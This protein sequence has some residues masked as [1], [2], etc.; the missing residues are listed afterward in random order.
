M[1]TGHASKYGELQRSSYQINNSLPCVDRVILERIAKVSIDYCNS[2][3]LSHEAYIKHLKIN[4]SK[5]Y[6]INNVLIA[7]DDWNENFRYT[8]YFKKKRNEILSKFKNE[9]LKLGKLLQYA[10]RQDLK[11]VRDWQDS[12][13]RIIRQIISCIWSMHIRGRFRS[14]SQIWEIT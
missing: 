12:V 7:L 11:M 1:K 5:K 6:S 8:E 14:I 2:L 4:A 10:I 9:R 13:R 3:K